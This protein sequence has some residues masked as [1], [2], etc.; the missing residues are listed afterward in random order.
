[1]SAPAF[2][3][4]ADNAIRYQWGRITVMRQAKLKSGRRDI[5]LLEKREGEPSVFGLTARQLQGMRYDDANRR[6]KPHFSQ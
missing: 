5:A 4:Q 1:M 2:R 3:L 6:G